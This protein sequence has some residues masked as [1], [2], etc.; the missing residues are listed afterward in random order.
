MARA[1]QIFGEAMVMVRFNNTVPYSEDGDF[2]YPEQNIWELGLT[3][4][5]PTITFNFPGTDV[6]IDAYGTSIPADILFQAADAIIEFKLVHYDPEAVAYYQ[7]ESLAGGSAG[8]DD[9]NT[10]GTM[11]YPGTPLGAGQQLYIP[12]NHF[13]GLEFLNTSIDSPPL[14]FPATYLMGPP[15]RYKIGPMRTM[16]EMRARA[17]PYAP[18]TLESTSYTAYQSRP[19]GEPGNSTSTPIPTNLLYYDV[20]IF[21]NSL[22]TNDDLEDL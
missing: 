9:T 15:V 17:L 16:F 5:S 10:M 18:L 8:F 22:V 4:E 21:G 6:K 20:P 7:R 2:E 12:N 11:N 13:V 14:T 19:S 3:V 1:F